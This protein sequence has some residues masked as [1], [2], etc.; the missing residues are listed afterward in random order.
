[1]VCFGLNTLG[2]LARI[3][4]GGKPD[5]MVADPLTSRIFAFSR[6]GASV[7][8]IEAGSNRV[9]KTLA[10]GGAPDAAAAD[11]NGDIFVD[12]FDK[13][14]L[15]KIDAGE[16]KVS[17]RW[18]VSPGTGPASLCL[19]ARRRR[20]FIGCE[21]RRMVVLDSGNGKF[22]TSLPIGDQVDGSAFDAGTDTLFHSC[23]D[24]TLSVI[25]EGDLDHFRVLENLATQ[26]G[27]GKMALDPFSHRVYLPCA[28]L[29]PAPSKEPGAG[30]AHGS[31]YLLEYGRD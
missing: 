1:V 16:L 3:P 13:N 14:L 19:D 29:G 7:R 24:G 26:K 31:F 25:H 20:L 2:I 23:R 12:L 27:A 10:L 22:V 21:N 18:D 15:I 17:K 6:E 4:F 8:V 9:I 30:I 11:G 5:V 28:E